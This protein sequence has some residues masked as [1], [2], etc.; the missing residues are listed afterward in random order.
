[1]DDHLFVNVRT[2]C[3]RYV[4][5]GEMKIS[6]FLHSPPP[7]SGSCSLDY[8]AVAHYVLT[9]IRATEDEDVLGVRRVAGAETSANVRR[10][11]WHFSLSVTNDSV[12]ST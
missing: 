10:D 2:V 6:Y 11:I 5:V 7:T 1:M 12:F 9:V 8:Q 4:T 3:S